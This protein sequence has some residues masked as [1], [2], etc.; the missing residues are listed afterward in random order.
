MMLNAAILD[1]HVFQENASH[2]LQMNN[3]ASE[4]VRLGASVNHVQRLVV[5]IIGTAMQILENAAAEA[6]VNHVPQVRN[7]VQ[8]HAG[9]D[10]V[11]YV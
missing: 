2:A 6:M 3:V 4:Y 11:L 8:E 9:L 5:Q 10:P 7:A 1:I